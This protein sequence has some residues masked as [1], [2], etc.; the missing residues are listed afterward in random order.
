[1]IRPIVRIALLVAVGAAAGAV[2][3]TLAFG[4]H[5]DVILEMDRDLPRNVSGF[6]PPERA[7]DMTFAW[8]GRTATMALPGLDRRGLWVCAVRFRGGRSDPTPQPTVDLAVDGI[9]L[10]RRT[11]TNTF[12][13]LEVTAPSMPRP[14][15]ILTVTSSSTV[16]PG[17]A[18]PRE[19]GIQV[20]RFQCRP[21]G[22]GSALPPRAAIVKAMLTGAFFA[23]ALGSIGV[24]TGVALGAT[25]LVA[26]AQALPLSSG[27]APYSPYGSQALWL[28][29]WITTAIVLAVKLI[30]QVR[31]QPLRQTAKFVVAF[32]GVAL[33]LK[34][35][36]L[37]HPSVPLIDAV[38]QAHRFESVLAGRYFFTQPMPSGVQFPYAIGLYVFASPWAALTRD[39]VTLLR[40]V[41]CASEAIGGALL[42]PMIVRT[43]GDRLTGAVA[44][45]LFSLVPLSYQVIRNANLTNAFGQSVALVTIAAVVVWSRP[46]AGFGPLAVWTALASLAFL[47][48][49]SS[50]ATL[51]VTLV[52]LAVLYRLCG[53]PPLRVPARSL[54]V[55]IT[56]AVV[57]STVT[58]YGHFADVY[59]Q[60]LRVRGTDVSAV[61]APAQTKDARTGISSGI[62]PLHVRAANAVVLSK[63][64]IGWPLLLLGC[65]GAWRLS[66]K[67]GRDPLVL[68]VAA[69]GIAFAVWIS[70]A[71]MRVDV[72]YQRYSLEFVGRVVYATYPALVILAAYG[73]MWAWRSG[74]VLRTASAS[75]LSLALIRGVQE[76]MQW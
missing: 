11:A 36:A 22:A 44:T 58:Y 62:T 34:L 37:L 20:D 73:A 17:Q 9:T 10:A 18:D 3:L 13:D 30:E 24:A 52:A 14:G 69:W 57:L 55:S 28:A 49:V 65:A 43:W 35:L 12:D 25:I 51:L 6:Y 50:F 38:F 41:V 54:A 47:S 27:P 70:V 72:Q 75:F 60:A 46:S 67:G 71:L 74:L 5:P 19:L 53:G 59:R 40:V 4:R 48:H 7:G 21:G 33:Y 45:V 68:A 1:L 56:I 76:W 31:R 32:S 26:T 15:L 39:H 8:T 64:S 16:I 61:S 2:C 29:V 66:I 23:A 42:Y 63:D